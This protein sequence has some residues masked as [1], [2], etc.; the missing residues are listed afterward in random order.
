MLDSPYF[1]QTVYALLGTAAYSV[2]LGG[3]ARSKALRA[4]RFPLAF[5]ATAIWVEA[6]FSCVKMWGAPY[7]KLVTIPGIFW[8]SV[9]YLGAL[10][11]TAQDIT[12][13]NGSIHL[14]KGSPL[15]L[16][17]TKVGGLDPSKPRTLCSLSWIGMAALIFWPIAQIAVGVIGTIFVTF[18]FLLSGYSPIKYY[19]IQI[20]D[21]ERVFLKVVMWG[22]VPMIPLLWAGIGGLVWLAVWG[23]QFPVVVGWYKI[24]WIVAAAGI[25]LLIVDRIIAQLMPGKYEVK[26]SG[27]ALPSMI[28]RFALQP[29]GNA[30]KTGVVTPFTILFQLIGTVKKRVCPPIVVDN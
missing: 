6:V 17:L 22:P 30:I 26:V 1:W 29:T 18:Q 20:L 4:L 10:V 5:V 15:Y 7:G 14:K 19:K 2:L 24:A 28:Y 16:V 25:V 11:S 9:F 8:A 23:A 12:A 13:Q 21:N 3:L 27:P